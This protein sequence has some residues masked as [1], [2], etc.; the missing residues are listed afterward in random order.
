M[1]AN[2]IICL[3]G[4]KAKRR[5][6]VRKV[7]GSNPARAVHFMNIVVILNSDNSESI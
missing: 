6:S 7:A 2:P 5:A 3:D 1:K 4:A